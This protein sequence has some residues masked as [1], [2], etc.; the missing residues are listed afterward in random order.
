MVNF[1]EALPSSNV[2]RV[3]N[4]QLVKSSTS[5][6][7]NHRAAGGARSTNDFFSKINIA[8]EE[9]DESLYWLE[10]IGGKDIKC[11]KSELTFLIRE[12]DEII[13][14]LTKARYSVKK[15]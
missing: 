10:I 3:I 14:I 7:V 2:T 4:F 1:C 9:A 5:T 6:G 11:N 15:K 12:A 8:V 13:R